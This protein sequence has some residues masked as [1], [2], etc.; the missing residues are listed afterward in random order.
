[1]LVALRVEDRQGNISSPVQRIIDLVPNGMC[2][3]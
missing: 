3:Y 2:G 1:M